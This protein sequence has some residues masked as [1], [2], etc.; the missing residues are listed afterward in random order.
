[1]SPLCLVP[2]G[3]E[4]AKGKERSTDKG[5]ERGDIRKVRNS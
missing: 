1:M 3:Q 2:E 5:N 4:L